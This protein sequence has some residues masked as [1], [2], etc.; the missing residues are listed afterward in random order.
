MPGMRPL[1]SPPT[2]TDH[3]LGA[4]DAEIVIVEHGDYDCPHTRAA[5]GVLKQLMVEMPGK[6]ALVFRH[7]PLRHLHQNAQQL[8]EWMEAITSPERYWP[9]HER[10][11]AQRRMSLEIARQELSELGFDVEQ[12]AAGAEAAR[13]RVERDAQRGRADG[14]HSTPSFFFNGAPFDGHYDV[15][16]LRAQLA[17]APR[18]A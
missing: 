11:M 10:L 14:V 17:A 12:L 7:F 5:H 15:A 9:A 18:R 1:T 16:T 8:A 2:S 4:L 13:E 3:V 6:L